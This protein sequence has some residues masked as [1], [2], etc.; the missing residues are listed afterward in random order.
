MPFTHLLEEISRL[1]KLGLKTELLGN[2]AQESRPLAIKRPSRKSLNQPSPMTYR[3]G[4]EEHTVY[5]TRREAECMILLL[6][7]TTVNN[8]AKKLGLS[9]RTVEYY[10]KNMKNKV[11]CRTK[12]E[13]VELVYA[14]DFI[15]NLDF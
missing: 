12:F 2:K 15:N 10:I 8:I 1:K 4:E 11:G 13:L 5:F 14:S 7:G 6:R 3:L 9:P